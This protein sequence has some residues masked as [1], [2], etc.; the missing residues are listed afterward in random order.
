MDMKSLK[1]PPTEKVCLRTKEEMVSYL[2]FS[3][4]WRLNWLFWD[5]ITEEWVKDE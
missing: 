3:E 4:N 5:A 2:C 1:V